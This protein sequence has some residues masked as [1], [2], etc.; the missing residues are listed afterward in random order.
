[1]WNPRLYYMP[2]FLTQA[3]A[4]DPK[5][6]SS[7]LLNLLSRREKTQKFVHIGLEGSAQNRKAFTLHQ[8]TRLFPCP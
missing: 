3:V 5:L 1:M 2:Y 4:R 6:Y 8:C 7:N